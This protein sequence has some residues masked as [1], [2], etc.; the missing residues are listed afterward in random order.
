MSIK[1]TWVIIRELEEL[2]FKLDGLSKGACLLAG[3]EGWFPAILDI[4]GRVSPVLPVLLPK[5][6]KHLV[7]L[8]RWRPVNDVCELC[9]YSGTYYRFVLLGTCEIQ[10]AQC[11]CVRIFGGTAWLSACFL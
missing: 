11:C 6:F 2:G 4:L 8:H 7:G 5:T 1:S 10:A 9:K 3:S